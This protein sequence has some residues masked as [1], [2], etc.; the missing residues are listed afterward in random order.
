MICFEFFQ[1][2]MAVLGSN[3]LINHVHGRRKQHFDIGLGGGVC[4]RFGQQA[5]TDPGIADQHNVFFLPDKFQ[6]HE[7]EEQVFLFFCVMR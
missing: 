6:I 4:N 5:F 1:Q 2:F 3:Q 7:A